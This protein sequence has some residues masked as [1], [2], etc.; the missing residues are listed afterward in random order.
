MLKFVHSYFAYLVTA[1][2][3]ISTTRFLVRY[4]LS[5]DYTPTDFRLALITF[6]SSHTQLLIGLLLYFVSDKFL[7]WNEYSFN[8][9]VS[10]DSARF[11]LIY[12]PIVNIIAIAFITRGYSLHKKRRVSNLK[13]KAIGFHYLLGLVLILF[14][15][16]SSFWI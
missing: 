13:F 14:S 8:D 1:L 16:P 2:L 3:V 5:K 9:I 11:Y 6:I 15:I 7:L 10:I 4:A 12:H